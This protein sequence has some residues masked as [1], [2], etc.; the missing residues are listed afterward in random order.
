MYT[1]HK[2][3]IDFISEKIKCNSKGS[4]KKIKRQTS[5]KISAKPMLDTGLL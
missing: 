5:S 2:E 4:I 1:N 3:K